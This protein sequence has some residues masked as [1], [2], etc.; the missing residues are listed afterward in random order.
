MTASH[1]RVVAAASLGLWLMGCAGG[2]SGFF[3]PSAEPP[4]PPPVA[5]PAPPPPNMN[6]ADFVGRW[7]YAAY[8]KEADRSRTVGAARAQCNNAYTIGRGATGGILMHLAD[9][10]EPQELR[11]KAGADGK[12]YLG[13]EGP[14]PDSQDREIVRFDGRELVMRWVDPEISARYGTS[15]YVRCGAPAT[16]GGKR[17]PG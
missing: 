3:G 13:P 17:N 12:A 9:A 1:V 14:A 2:G 5:E 10:K 16:A 7:G 11:L 4:P 6:P 15:V 8:H